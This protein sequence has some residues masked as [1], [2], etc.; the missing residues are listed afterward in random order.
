M[1]NREGF[2]GISKKFG[3]ALIGSAKHEHKPPEK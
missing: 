1:P 3:A 2:K